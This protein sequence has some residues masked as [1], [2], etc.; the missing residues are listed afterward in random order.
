MRASG[1]TASMAALLTLFTLAACEGPTGPEGPAGPQGPQ[2]PTGAQGPPGPAGSGVQ[3]EWFE[4][5]ITQ[6]V[7]GTDAVNTGG[8]APGIVCYLSSDGQTWLTLDTVVSEDRACG[9]IQESASTY[10]G[11]AV[12]SPSFVNSGWSIRIILFWVD[13][14]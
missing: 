2:G 14:G 3:Y 4:G 13:G 7:M 5:P 10:S 1:W 6:E 11:G 12:V 9:V 8:V